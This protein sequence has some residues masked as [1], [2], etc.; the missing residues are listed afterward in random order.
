MGQ[1]LASHA[2]DGCNLLFGQ[3]AVHSVEWI[4]GITKAKQYTSNGVSP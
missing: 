2:P 3:V 4:E 1:I